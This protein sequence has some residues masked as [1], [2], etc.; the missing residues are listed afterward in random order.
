VH[1]AVTIIGRRWVHARGAR[2]G[3]VAYAK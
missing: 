2:R 1:L 3:R